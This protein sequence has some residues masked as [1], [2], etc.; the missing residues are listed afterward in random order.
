MLLTKWQSSSWPSLYDP[1]MPITHCKGSPKNKCHLAL[2]SYS[3]RRKSYYSST[4]KSKKLKGPTTCMSHTQSIPKR[5]FL[6]SSLKTVSNCH[7]T[8]QWSSTP[9]P[10]FVPKLRPGSHFEQISLM[11]CEEAP[12][13][14]TLLLP[15]PF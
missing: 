1:K 12:G 3:H 8:K 11:A 13:N 7:N 9:S 2:S 15:S 5:M 4:G 6:E 10:L 14:T